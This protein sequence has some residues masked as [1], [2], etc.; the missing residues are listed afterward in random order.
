MYYSS[1]NTCQNQVKLWALKMRDDV[2]LAISKFCL[3]IKDCRSQTSFKN[4]QQKACDRNYYFY[5]QNFKIAM[6]NP[7]LAFGLKIPIDLKE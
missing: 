7:V 6:R 1:V 4:L 2:R 3:S 5:D